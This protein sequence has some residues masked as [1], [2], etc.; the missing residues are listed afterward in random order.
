M[1][2]SGLVKVQSDAKTGL[3]LLTYIVPN[4][5]GEFSE[6]QLVADLTSGGVLAVYGGG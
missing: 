3:P 5:S 4:P 1:R 2:G 6:G